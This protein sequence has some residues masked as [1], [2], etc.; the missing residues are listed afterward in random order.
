MGYGVTVILIHQVLWA[1]D[2]DSSVAEFILSYAEGL[3]TKVKTRS[4]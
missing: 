2:L 3:T 1:Q 4:S